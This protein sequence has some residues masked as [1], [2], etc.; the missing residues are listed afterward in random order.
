MTTLPE[1]SRKKVLSQN[2]TMA[3]W[4]GAIARALR[5]YSVDDQR[6]FA[7]AGID[8]ALVNNPSQRIPVA[9][10]TRLWDLSVAA[11]GDPGFGLVVARHVNLT[12]FH[13]L[14]VAA[15]ASATVREAG[16]MICR[17]ASMISDGIAMRLDQPGSDVG[18]VLA[19]RA[20]YPRFADAC[21]E[22]ALA[23]VYL[24]ARQLVPNAGASR[25]SFKHPC[26][27]DPARYADFFHCP[28]TF[29]AERDAIYTRLDSL[30]ATELPSSSPELARVNAALCEAYLAEHQG[31]AS[32]RVRELIRLELQHG[33][34]PALSTI[35]SALAM[36]ERTLQRLLRDEGIQF[37]DLLDQ[38]RAKLALQLLV[39]GSLSVGRIAEQ[40]G[41]D[42]MSSFSRACRRWHGMSPRA[43]RQSSG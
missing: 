11:S 16:D 40:L 22:A 37:R 35:A 41:F 5:S 38:V 15:V 28:V 39:N 24:S 3:T 26:R 29:G 17:F 25:V 21:V 34:T 14:G 4:A 30:P 1:Q 23:S 13:A 31:Q 8:H 12:T 20:G 42:S 6:L 32:T 7:D 10:M 9:D 2:T 27:S 19:M 43:L 18:L 36:S 33:R